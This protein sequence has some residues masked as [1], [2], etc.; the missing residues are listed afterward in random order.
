MRLV[1]VQA[2]IDPAVLV[3]DEALAVG[4]EYFQKKCFKRLD[5]LKARGTSILLVSHSC[6][7]INT[8][9]DRAY[10]MHM[11]SSY[12][13]VMLIQSP[14]VISD[15]FKRLIR[16]GTNSTARKKD[17]LTNLGNQ[18]ALPKSQ[19][20]YPKLP[21]SYFILQK[22]VKFGNL[23][24]LNHKNEITGRFKFGE[25]IRITVEVLSSA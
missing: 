17:H 11:G 7:Q 14:H 20:Q 9:C 12:V 18:Q 21:D 8:H 6:A 1:A 23:K 4:D 19:A 3:V 24:I 5:E 25:T 15:F 13:K 16:I 2:H 22:V 10:L